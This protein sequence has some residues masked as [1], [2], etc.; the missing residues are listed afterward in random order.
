MTIKILQDMQEA[1]NELKQAQAMFDNAA[2]QYRISEATYRILAA[3]E[4]IQAIR[5]EEGEKQ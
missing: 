5:F 2:N 4:R 1:I 3:Q